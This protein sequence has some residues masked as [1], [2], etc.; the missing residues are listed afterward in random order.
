MMYLQLQPNGDICFYFFASI[1]DFGLIGRFLVPSFNAGESFAMM[2]AAFVALVEGVT[3]LLSGLFGTANG[4]P[5]SV[6]NAG[7]IGLSKGCAAICCIHDFLFCFRE[8]R[9][10]FRFNSNIHC[11]CIILHLL[12]LCWCWWFRFSP[13]LPA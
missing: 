1:F 9:S 11:G 4:S 13:V 8:I 6:E 12:R 10:H 7:L 3:I 5:E 2:V